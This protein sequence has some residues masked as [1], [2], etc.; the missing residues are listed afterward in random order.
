MSTSEEEANLNQWVRDQLGP[1]K[2][3]RWWHTPNPL[4]G[5]VEPAYMLTHNR[6]KLYAFLK[7]SRDNST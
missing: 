2:A 6:E 1:S 7:A 3:L 4:L 5:Q